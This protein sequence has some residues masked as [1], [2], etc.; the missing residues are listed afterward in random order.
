MARPLRLQFPGAFYHVMNRGTA[1]QPIFNSAVGDRAL[2]LSVLARAVKLWR[3]RVI[4]FSRPV[5][6]VS[7]TG[8]H[9][10]HTSAAIH[11]PQRDKGRYL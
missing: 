3:V 10:L 1:R 6:I 7:D 8:R 5:Q 4:S 2:F 9:L 11:P